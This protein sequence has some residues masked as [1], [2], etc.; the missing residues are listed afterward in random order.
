ML[1]SGHTYIGDAITHQGVAGRQ[2]TAMAYCYAARYSKQLQFGVV[3]TDFIA[4]G[5]CWD[6]FY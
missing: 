3:Q 5:Q 4:R 1:T 6:I 2:Y